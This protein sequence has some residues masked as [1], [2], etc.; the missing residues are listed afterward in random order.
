MTFVVSL[1]LTRNFGNSCLKLQEHFVL[2]FS[3]CFFRLKNFMWFFCAEKR[4]YNGLP[5]FMTQVA[6]EELKNL[7]DDITECNV[8]YLPQV[9]W[10]PKWVWGGLVVEI[11]F[12]SCLKVRIK[13]YKGLRCQEELQNNSYSSRYSYS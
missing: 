8:I 4:T 9:S 11:C 12:F 6:K 2:I 7:D 13:N 10:L 5:N 1:I 3:F